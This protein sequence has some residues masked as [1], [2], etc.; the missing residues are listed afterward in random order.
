M[1]QWFLRTDIFKAM[2]VHSSKP[3]ELLL[4]VRAAVEVRLGVGKIFIEFVRVVTA[5]LSTSMVIP[6]SAANAD[7]MLNGDGSDLAYGCPLIGHFMQANSHLGL[8]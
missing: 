6:T 8:K 7:G 1:L 4:T 5:S 2:R 3:P